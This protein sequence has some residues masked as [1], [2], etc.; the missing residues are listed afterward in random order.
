MS[1]DD[2]YSTHTVYG[3]IE[4]G[5]DASSG[6]LEWICSDAKERGGDICWQSDPGETLDGLFLVGKAEIPERRKVYEDPSLMTVGSELHF[7]GKCR[8]CHFFWVGH[9]CRHGITCGFCH[10][11]PHLERKRQSKQRNKKMA[12]LTSASA[13]TTAGS[14]S[15]SSW[16]AAPSLPQ[17]DRQGS[18][19]EG[20]RN[21]LSP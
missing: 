16:M 2:A 10:W 12:S 9:P 13:T 15:T 4:L 7:Q 3:S 11:H 5:S 18:R 14:A 21:L 6:L 17:P 19:P 20:S 1:T 8:P